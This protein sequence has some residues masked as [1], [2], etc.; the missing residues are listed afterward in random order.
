MTATQHVM[1]CPHAVTAGLDLGEMHEGTP[2]PGCIVIVCTEDSSGNV[3][4]HSH[5]AAT[6]DPATR[7]NPDVPAKDYR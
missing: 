6:L 5:D 2:D 3:L 1:T 7:L 4:W